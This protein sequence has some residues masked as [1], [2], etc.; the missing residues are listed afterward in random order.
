MSSTK[1]DMLVNWALEKSVDIIG[2]NETNILEQQGKFLIKKDSEYVGFWT[3]ANEF[4]LKGSGVGI[5]IRKAWE[6]HIGQVTRFSN[7]YIDVLFVF[8]KYKILVI[9]IYIPPNDKEEKKKIQ[10]KVINKMR[11]CE[12]NK[13]KVIVMGDFN[14]IRS[15]ELD[16]NKE[17]S[18]RKQVLPLLRWLE[19]SSLED[20]F[21]KVHADEKEFTWS[22]GVSSSRIDYIWASRVL[23]HSIIML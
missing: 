14:D 2:I 17:I 10:Q 16:Q 22:N 23:S 6:K 9:S 7:Y 3:S 8:K 13:I 15:R 5:L 1:L 19:S 21:R 4:K 18:N 20:V 12:K 11:E